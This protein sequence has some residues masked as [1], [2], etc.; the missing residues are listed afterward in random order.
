MLTQILRNL[1]HRK[2]RTLLTVSGIAV[3]VATI[4][5]LGAMG[6]GLR[7]GY[8]SMF[9]G[10]GADLTVMQK[11]SYDITLSSVD[12]DVID[13]VAALPGVRAVTG[14]IVGNVMAPG[15]P[16]FFIFGYD[17]AGFAIERFKIVEGH[18]LGSRPG[19]REI[20]LGGQAADA[21]KLTVGD[22]LRVTGGAFRVAGIYETGSGFE[23]AAAVISLADAQQLLQKHR[24]VGAVQ[25][26]LKDARQAERVR[27]RIERQFP[28]LAVSQSGQVADQ[29]QMV[30]MM[31]GFAWGIALL[32]IVIGG[33]GMTNT[34]MMSTFERTREIGTLRAV[35]WGRWRVL[36]MV[37]T[38]SVALGVVGGLLG[39]AAG[40]A[41]IGPMTR[42]PAM[43]FLQGQLTLPLLGQAM[44]TAI[45]LGGVGGIYP[46]WWASQLMPVEAMRYEGG[47]GIG[48]RSREIKVKHLRGSQERAGKLMLGSETLRSLWR[49]RGRTAL[50]VVGISMGL[51]AILLLNGMTDGMVR[52]FSGMIGASDIDLVAR[53][54]GAADMGYSAID[55]R[56]G[57]QVAALPGVKSVSGIVIGVVMLETN[58]IPFFIVMGYAPHEPAISHFKIVHG[59]GLVGN[60][61]V[62]LGR[63]AA[64]TLKVNVG[65][66]L[67]LGEVGFRVVGL[68]ETGLSWE[69]SGGVISTRDAQSLLGKP[70]QVTLYGIKVN[71]PQQA[72]A[73]ARQ[74]NA[75][76]SEVEVAASSEFVETLPDMQ[77][78]YTMM[79]AIGAL[80]ILVGGI[81]M[82]NT[83]VMSVF[84]RTREIGTLRALG[85]RKLR[86]LVM[87]LKESLALSLIGVLASIVM[88]V[89]LG[90]L[91]RRIPGWG[92]WLIV[93]FTPNLFV[94]IVII[95]AGL[96]AVGGL[97]PAW[98]AAQLSPVEALRYE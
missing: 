84:E 7:S 6:E 97:Y 70:R 18:S 98:R 45:V 41:L 87:V 66:V 61:E 83:M 47:A 16:Y 20:L 34:V 60:R 46:A 62:I 96:G 13:Q 29:Q 30:S 57:R 92:E 22:T 71:D 78:M 68:Y 59:R 77:T 28:R 48:S 5:A 76:I 72:E 40:A 52:E 65:D 12:E 44:G 32:A 79:G 88:S 89:I 90:A 39:C 37:L 63:A 73:I 26:K 75:H 69:E 1:T 74:I 64:D 17:P 3:G 19:S 50:T 42:S 23:D 10:S 85:W 14:M 80:A 56:V 93:A 21:L 31:Q 36:V 24:Q 49:A 54:A 11:G 82:M 51:T 81:S 33:V 35:G 4:V 38:E 55:E 43:A 25:I 67:R 15:M 27:A 8:A 95:A 53:Q 58:E 91:M 2:T 94:R 86:V 9:S